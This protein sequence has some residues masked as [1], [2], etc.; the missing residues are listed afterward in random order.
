MEHKNKHFKFV[1]DAENKSDTFPDS[2]MKLMCCMATNGGISWSDW[3]QW[4]E[5]RQTSFYTDWEKSLVPGCVLRKQLGQ[6]CFSS[7]SLGQALTWSLCGFILVLLP[8]AWKENRSRQ[9]QGNP[10]SLC[11]NSSNQDA[12]K[13]FIISFLMLCALNASFI[14][15]FP[16]L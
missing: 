10:D 5:S 12:E 1:Q 8:W 9:C 6:Q 15:K 16:Y 13:L 7:G 3:R 14:H 2:Q 11:F 4:L